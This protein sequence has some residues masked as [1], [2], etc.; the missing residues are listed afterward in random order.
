MVKIKEIIDYIESHE[1]LSLIVLLIIFSLS[2]IFG[3]VGFRIHNVFLILLCY[4]FFIGF[5]I[6]D[7]GYVFFASMFKEEGNK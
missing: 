6:L 4:I 5:M 2:L 3:K 1:L 7:F